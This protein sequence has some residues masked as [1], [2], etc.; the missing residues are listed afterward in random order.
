MRGQK[1]PCTWAATY[2]ELSTI[3]ELA[4]EILA[5]WQGRIEEAVSQA[6][7]CLTIAE[8]LREFRARAWRRAVRAYERGGLTR[9]RSRQLELF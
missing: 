5:R 9:R 2:R 4:Q 7:C 1:G 8:I 3:D 6:S